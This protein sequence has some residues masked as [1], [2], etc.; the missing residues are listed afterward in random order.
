MSRTIRA[1]EAAERAFGP[2]AL[3]AVCALGGT[4]LALFFVSASPWGQAVLLT[5][6]AVG[7]LGT[8][9]IAAYLVVHIRRLWM[10]DR[11]GSRRVAVLSAGSLGGA[12]L[13]GLAVVVLYA[14]SPAGSAGVAWVHWALGGAVA[15]L[16][17]VHVLTTASRG[18]PALRVIR[19]GTLAVLVLLVIG[20]GVAAGMRWTDASA[21]LRSVPADYPRADDGS[22]F[23]AAFTE[24]AHG[25]FVDPRALTGSEQC[26]VC[27]AEI[28]HEWSVSAHR[29]SGVD[30]PLIATATAPA[31]AKGGVAAARFCAACHEPVALLSGALRES[32]FD[33]PAELREQGVSCL[34]CHGI[35]SVPGLRGNG[36]MVYAPPETFAFFNGGSRLGAGLNR[37]LV[38]SFPED[39]GRAMRPPIMDNSHQC[40][41][42]HTVNAH[43]GLNGFGFV[44]LHNENDDWSVSAFA[45]GVGPEDEIVRCQSCHMGRVPGS[46]D[47][48]AR[49]SGGSHRSH[50]F[51]AA[52]TFVAQHFGDAEQLRLTEEFLRGEGFPEEIRHLLPEGPAVSL[53]IEAPA[54][55]RPGA[56]LRV[57]VVLTNRAVGHAFPAGPNEVNEAWVELTVRDAQGRLLFESG[58]LDERGERDPD[59]FALVSVPVDADGEEILVT[60]GLAAGFRLRRAILAGASDGESWE[61]AIPAEFAGQEIVIAARLRYRKA[62]AAFARLMR[63]F[64]DAEV[65]LTDISWAERRVRIGE[66]GPGQNGT[67]AGPQPSG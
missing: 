6:L 34:V 21:V 13:S 24:T 14:G 31:E 8:P 9:L 18:V 61:V 26:G 19:P 45:H 37:V 67:R 65:P 55:A 20:L 50:R 54:V 33:I 56:P 38:R 51:L 15:V 10:R 63:E 4:G 22:L 7:M 49:R 23:A 1:A 40:S 64:S 39:H 28:F 35:Q 17:P 5:H 59:A 11:A 44:R 36:A 12:L 3:V 47:P 57:G 48:V 16:L 32:S 53:E 29:R 60:G 41:S 27:H 42:C 2:G 58:G 46:K 25:G 66:A 30:N 52:N 43:E 62:D